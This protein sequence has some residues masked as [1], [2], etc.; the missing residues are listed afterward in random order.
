M[1]R[2]LRLHGATCRRLGATY[3]ETTTAFALWWFEQS[4]VERAVLEIGLG[5]RHDACNAVDSELSVV[6]SIA[7]EHTQ[8]LGHTQAQIAAE[9]GC[10]ARPGKPTLVGPM[11]REAER[12]LRNTITA[13]GGTMVRVGHE[14][15]LQEQE[16]SGRGSRFGVTCL[17]QSVALSTRLLGRKA[18]LNAGLAASAA[19]HLVRAETRADRFRG[20]KGSLQRGVWAARWPARLQVISGGPT[21]VLDVAHNAAAVASLVEDW[22]NLWPRRRPVILA[23]L[24]DDKP[25]GAIGSLFSKIASRVVVTRPDSERAFDPELLALTWQPDFEHVEVVLNPGKAWQRA[26]KLAG[27][28]G[29]ILV[30]GSHFV[31]GPVMRHLG[32]DPAVAVGPQEEP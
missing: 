11:T 23:G 30:T 15:R 1:R 21:L 19:L 32:L 24:L 14:I 2:F 26:S 4:G 9:K 8:W 31:V 20:W 3:F 5:G 16:C 17:G 18:A 7:L 29:C 6:T 22:Q 25:A 12:A 27:K 10:V 28:Q 13:L